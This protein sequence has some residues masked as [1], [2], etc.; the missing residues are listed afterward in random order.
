MSP[1]TMC[2]VRE[3]QNNKVMAKMLASIW[4]RASLTLA[5]SE[6]ALCY[7]S[8][9]CRPASTSNSLNINMDN[10]L[11]FLGIFTSLQTLLT[12]SFFSTFDGTCKG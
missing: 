3:W 4:L 5:L 12:L 10:S 8:S 1:K 11:S 7:L 9:T 6:G 2:L